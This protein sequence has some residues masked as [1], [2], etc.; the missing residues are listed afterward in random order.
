MILFIPKPLDLNL[1]WIQRILC[2]LVSI[3]SSETLSTHGTLT[4]FSLIETLIETCFQV[5]IS[6]NVY[7]KTAFITF[8]HENIIYMYI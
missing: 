2:I 1:Y 8:I 7:D 6:W 5:S 4:E 3:L